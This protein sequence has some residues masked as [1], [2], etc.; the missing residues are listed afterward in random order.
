MSA[1]LGGGLAGK[2]F[3][4][5]TATDIVAVVDAESGDVL[6]VVL[7]DRMPSNATVS[8]TSGD[9][10]TA[11]E[12]FLQH[13]GL[14]DEGFVESVQVVNRGGVAAYEVLWKDT[15][16]TAAPRFQVL[17][18]AST[19]AAFAFVDLRMQLKLTAPLV[20]KG[21]AT[22][23][24]LAAVDIPGEAAISADLLISFPASGSQESVWQ[25]GMGVPTAT[26]ADVYE[27]GALVSVDAVTGQATIVKSS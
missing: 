18:N 22:D 24:A 14:S 4:Q 17:V 13:A 5:A 6:E 15:S 16:A 27:H 1:Q 20:G 26:Q 19:G 12:G 3:Y 2:P 23:L 11:A 8:M 9:A 25:V 21:R 10:R 7:E